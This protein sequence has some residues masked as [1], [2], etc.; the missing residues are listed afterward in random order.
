MLSRARVI[1]IRQRERERDE[2]LNEES[3]SGGNISM[4]KFGRKQIF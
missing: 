1:L 4:S 2:A 3:V